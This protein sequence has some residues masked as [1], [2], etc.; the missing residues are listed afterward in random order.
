MFDKMSK[1][2]LRQNPNGATAARKDIVRFMR[3]TPDL[4][5]F[6]DAHSLNKHLNNEN[7]R[8]SFGS[9]GDVLLNGVEPVNLGAVRN[10]VRQNPGGNTFD[11][12]PRDIPAGNLASAVNSEFKS[13]QLQQQSGFSKTSTLAMIP[14]GIAVV[15]TIDSFNISNADD[16]RTTCINIS[17]NLTERAFN[18]FMDLV[19]EFVRT[20]GTYV[21]NSI[22]RNVPFEEY[23]ADSYAIISQIA[24]QNDI[25]ISVYLE[26]CIENVRGTVLKDIK[27]FYDQFRPIYG[28]NID[29][30]VC[31]G[32]YNIAKLTN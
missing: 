19:K 8:I 12:V 21:Q 27:I 16:F 4:Q 30:E 24:E 28:D 22:E 3:D 9:N 29:C 1:E 15:K 13:L 20:M 18:I 10:Q 32:Q 23:L 26:S 6:N 2:T 7:I 25:D 17:Q 14:T 11:S 31:K 5:V